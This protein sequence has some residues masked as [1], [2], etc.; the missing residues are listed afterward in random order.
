MPLFN[1]NKT[2]ELGELGGLLFPTAQLADYRQ[3]RLGSVDDIL[4]E[5][6]SAR[7]AYVC[8]REFKD[9]IEEVAEYR[10]LDASSLSYESQEFYQLGLAASQMAGEDLSQADVALIALRRL[11]CPNGE[12]HLAAF[13]L[14]EEDMNAAT[15]VEHDVKTKLAAIEMARNSP[16]VISRFR[17][18][19]HN[20][21]Q[22][23]E[24]ID[25]KYAEAFWHLNV[26]LPEYV[27]ILR[28]R[29]EKH[30]TRLIEQQADRLE[31]YWYGTGA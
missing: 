7:A 1:R 26:V 25:D 10:D 5:L 17:K 20:A 16:D 13:Q 27:E 2:S 3:R 22:E 24:A 31:A 23:R 11:R 29:T 9:L 6:A 4:N 30:I 15:V 19:A 28:V 8:F 14:L 12:D 21:T 18:A